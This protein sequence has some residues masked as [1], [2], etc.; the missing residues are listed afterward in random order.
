MSSRPR[1]SG[2]SCG[3]EAESAADGPPW[4]AG[5]EKDRKRKKIG[6][7]AARA[8]KQNSQRIKQCD[9]R[10][11]VRDEMV[12]SAGRSRNDGKAW[13]INQFIA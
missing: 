2:P 5:A 8:A 9:L 1:P 4:A 3:P 11:K 7:A 10:Q 12:S 13:G 6:H